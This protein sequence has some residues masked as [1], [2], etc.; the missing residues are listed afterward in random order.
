MENKYLPL[1]KW[2][3]FNQD[4]LN[5]VIATRLE[6]EKSWKTKEKR[7]TGNTPNGCATVDNR[8]T[9]RG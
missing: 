9:R 3:R 8:Q 7:Q 6:N 4:H 5:L 1:N 2:H